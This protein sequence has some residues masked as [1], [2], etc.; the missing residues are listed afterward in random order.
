MRFYWRKKLLNAPVVIDIFFTPVDLL[1]HSSFDAIPI[2]FYEFFLFQ[3]T[4]EL[5]LI[6]FLF[7]IYFYFYMCIRY[8]SN[9]YKRT[10]GFTSFEND[11][12]I[13]CW[14]RWRWI[15]FIAGYGGPFVQVT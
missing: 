3:I 8:A 12:F 6:F 7:F 9:N 2:F 15:S 5:E 13:V 1:D 4:V 10:E 14:F 11:S